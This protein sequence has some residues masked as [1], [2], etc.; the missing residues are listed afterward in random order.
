MVQ[1]TLGRRYF[2]YATSNFLCT[3]IEYFLYCAKAAAR[4]YPDIRAAVFCDFERIIF[5]DNLDKE[6]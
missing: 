3:T 6:L 1:L 2:R 5:P 4:I